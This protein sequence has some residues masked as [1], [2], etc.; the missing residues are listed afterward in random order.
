[1]FSLE[2][3]RTDFFCDGAKPATAGKAAK[4]STTEEIFILATTNCNAIKLFVNKNV[5]IEENELFLYLE[6]WWSLMHL[7]SILYLKLPTF[8]FSCIRQPSA[9]IS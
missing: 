2:P 5:L 3:N 1:M 4:T 7:R 6:R 8:F 9:E